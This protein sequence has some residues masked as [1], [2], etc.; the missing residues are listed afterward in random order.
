MG[1]T[2]L[3]GGLRW[4]YGWT[5]GVQN[6]ISGI[7]A[8]IQESEQPGTAGRGFTSDVPNTSGTAKGGGA[9]YQEGGSLTVVKTSSR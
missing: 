3:G 7:V 5:A 6:D 9:I 2:L 1:R 4:H 8:Q